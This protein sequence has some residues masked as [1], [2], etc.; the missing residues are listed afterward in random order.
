[1]LYVYVCN[2]SMLKCRPH[3]WWPEDDLKCPSLPSTLFKRESLC[4]LLLWTLD[5]LAL[6]I[7]KVLPSLPPT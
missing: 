1:M 2:V 4:C 5:K 6:E 3:V 7:T